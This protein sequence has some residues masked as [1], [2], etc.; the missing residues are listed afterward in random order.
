MKRSLLAAA[1][2]AGLV[3]VARSALRRSA[4]QMH[5]TVP[6]RPL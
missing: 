6:S 1:A 5:R 4:T 3:A 2:V